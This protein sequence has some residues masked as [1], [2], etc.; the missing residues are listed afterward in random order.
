[1]KILIAL[2]LA[3]TLFAEE[4]GKLEQLLSASGENVIKK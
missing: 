1:M 4:E 2:A 3:T